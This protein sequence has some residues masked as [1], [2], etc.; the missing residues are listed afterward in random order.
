MLL[1]VG[2]NVINNVNHFKRRDGNQN[3]PVWEKTQRKIK[4][5][6]GTWDQFLNLR[7][8]VRVPEPT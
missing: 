4:E 1:L 5:K 2:R 7:G 3:R 6:E 8:A